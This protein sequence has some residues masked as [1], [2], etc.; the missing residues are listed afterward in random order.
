MDFNE[1]ALE[2]MVKDR[3]H[4]ARLDAAV[5]RLLATNRVPAPRV[6]LR[7]SLGL[8]LIRL[9]RWV[10]GADCCSGV[11]GGYCS[12]VVGARRGPQVG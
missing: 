12:G 8:T 6:P 11:V 7:V 4:R 1:Y 3:L 9:G 5:Y 10:R 2:I